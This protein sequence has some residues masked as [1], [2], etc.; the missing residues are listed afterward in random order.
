M[1]STLTTI[2]R[3]N[4]EWR[5]QVGHLAI[6]ELKKKARGAA[7]GWAW[8]AVKPIVFIAVFWFALEV[9]LRAGDSSS[10]E[11]PYFVW[12]VAGL[13]PW[14]YIADM[15]G[16]GS[17]VL[18]RYSYLVDKV[19]FPLS[20]IST[21]YSLSTLIIN[22]VL[23][24]LLF[25][26]YALYGMPWDIYLLQVPI[27]MVLMFAFWNMVSVMMS[28]L[29][30]IS[31][32]FGQLMKALSQ[33]LFWLSGILF[34]MQ[35]LAPAGFGWAADVMLFNPITFFVTAFR[36]ALCDK[37]WFWED[38]VFFG[39]FAVVFVATLVASTLIY[40]HFNEEVSDV[41]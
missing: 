3:D 12:L 19:K 20:C 35:V 36:G 11:Y 9:G 17:D 34:N 25:V 37:V 16:T 22:A 38:P 26:I 28:Q 13:I 40:K 6:F 7:L 41:L 18:H 31:K 24:V 27:L 4:W 2:L 1:L 23:F 32:D 21:L 8:L 10:P 39:S 29:S 5:R 15:I 30:G 14:F 33:P